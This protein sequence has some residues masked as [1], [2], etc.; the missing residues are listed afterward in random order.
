M[1]LGWLDRK[2]VSPR[3][4]LKIII[5]II[6]FNLRDHRFINLIQVMIFF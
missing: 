5:I 3:N 6:F 2:C 4:S 1:S